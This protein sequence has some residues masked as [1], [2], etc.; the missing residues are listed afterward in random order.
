MSEKK[1]RGRP[2]A[3]RLLIPLLLIGLLVGYLELTRTPA[4]RITVTGV[5][6]ATQVDVSSKLA[7]RLAEVRVDEGDTVRAGAVL[8][9]LDDSQLRDQVAGARATLAMMRTHTPQAQV[10]LALQREET[11]TQVEQTAAGVESA[12]ARLAQARAAYA[13]Q[14][15]QTR[16]QVAAAVAAL[17]AAQAKLDE[18]RHG[19]RPQELAAARA[20]VANA[21]A[22]RGRARADLDRLQR[23]FGEGAV[24]A[25]QLDEARA[26]AEST[27]AD[28]DAARQNADMMAAGPRVEEVRAAEA[29]VARAQ[30]NL[31]LARSGALQELVR[32]QDI[33]AAERAA[34][35]ARAALRWAKATGMQ[36]V[37][38]RQDVAASAAQT[39]QAQAA[40]RQAQSQLADTVLRAPLSGV[41]T[42]RHFEGG[43]TVAVGT[44]IVTVADLAHEYVIAYVGET[45]VDRIHRGQPARIRLYGLSAPVTGRVVRIEPAGAF[46]TERTQSTATRDIKAFEVKVIFDQP[47]PT[48]KPGMTADVT[49]RVGE[50][51]VAASSYEVG[52]EGVLPRPAG[53]GRGSSGKR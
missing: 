17:R 8:A 18:L 11:Q 12:D 31:S 48:L 53:A 42:A 26:A 28:W 39:A 3:V 32:K 24:S 4:D 7:G 9:R 13:L 33:A 23:L 2:K 30:A 19:A 34:A 35:Q 20:R 16:D 21:Q 36:A 43:E 10:G 44:P 46:A 52:D 25:Q 51:G 50:P 47:P 38:R 49:F 14:K 37:S 40:L 27:A 45:D 5:V 6:D 41:V 1:P 15:S 29:E 22:A